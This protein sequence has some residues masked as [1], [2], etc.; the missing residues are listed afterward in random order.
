MTPQTQRQQP[1]HIKRFW[2]GLAVLVL[3]GVAD[4]ILGAMNTATILISPHQG[5]DDPWIAVAGVGGLIALA[6]FWWAMEG[7]SLGRRVRTSI[8]FG[9]VGFIVSIL[10][11][12]FGG[13]VVASYRDFPSGQTSRYTEVLHLSRA[14]YSHGKS[15][16]GAVQTMP[17][18]A[19]F[20][21]SD[22]DYDF[23]RAHR[24][25]EEV[26]HDPKG[27]EIPSKGRFCIR[28][29]LEQAGGSALRVLHAG[30]RDLPDGSV[31]LCPPGTPELPDRF[32]Q[33]WRAAQAQ[34][35]TV[36]PELLAAYRK[37]RTV[38]GGLLALDPALR[39]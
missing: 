18:W 33:A 28:V 35:T 3:I 2:Y 26:N 1:T 6:G 13:D 8:A 19:N 37:A 27:D 5:Q 24:S 23:V 7:A 16:H 4:A 30:T 11:I 17:L 9:F 36:S 34:A 31:I 14:Y 21:V 22:A 15:P 10:L 38:Q 12:V 25:P 29:E 20:D 39:H 32:M